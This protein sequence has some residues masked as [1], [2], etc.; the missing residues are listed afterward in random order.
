MSTRRKK[1]QM[2]ILGFIGTLCLNS[3]SSRNQSRKKTAVLGYNQVKRI[4]VV[5]T[6]LMSRLG[7]KIP[8]RLR[9]IRSW[10]FIKNMFQKICF[11]NRG[12]CFASC[13]LSF[14]D[15]GCIFVV[16]HL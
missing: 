7:L 1:Q 10:L 15:P 3:L 12:S 13:S 4:R 8:F 9:S 2:I 5:L 11:E 6:W 14:G 16:F